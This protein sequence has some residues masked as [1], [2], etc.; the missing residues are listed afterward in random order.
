LEWQPIPEDSVYSEVVVKTLRPADIAVGCFLALLGLFIVYASSMIRVGVERALSPRTIPSAV[1]FL[2]FVCGIGLAVKSWRFR[3]EDP[4]IHWPDRQGTKIILVS[5]IILALYI[6]LMNPL[7]LPLSTF[8]YVT[9][10]ILYL[11][12]SKWVTAIV[13]GL[14]FGIVSYYVFIHLLKLSFPMGFLFE[15]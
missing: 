13:T 5:L 14:V 10:S 8:L 1:G 2:I 15:G 7:G 11:K 12:P 4:K 6:V 3:G 9:I